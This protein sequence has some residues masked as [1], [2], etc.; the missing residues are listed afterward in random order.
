MQPEI[1]VDEARRESRLVFESYFL[2]SCDMDTYD[3]TILKSPVKRT[4][5]QAML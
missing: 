1:R 4:C 3:S 2:A 5:L